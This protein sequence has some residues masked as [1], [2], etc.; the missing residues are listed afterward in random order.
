MPAGPRILFLVQCSK[1]KH[2]GGVPALRGPSAPALLPRALATRLRSARARLA[3]RAGLDE[4]L[5][6]PAWDR[7]RGTAYAAARD[8]GA[9]PDPRAPVVILSGAYGL[10]LAGE[11]AGLYDRKLTLSDW[12][13]GLLEECLPAAARALGCERVVAL[14]SASGDHA[15]LV[16]RADWRRAPGVRV[17]LG[18]P[19]GAGRGGLQVL[20]PRAAGQALAALLSDGMKA[21][22]TSSDGLSIAWDRVA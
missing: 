14:C 4:S 16:R 13:D 8:A 5:L 11:P 17:D 15:R 3:G 12:P 22:W 7:F 19:D 9:A 21:G 1:G 10:L 6:M 18:A 2:P 20:V